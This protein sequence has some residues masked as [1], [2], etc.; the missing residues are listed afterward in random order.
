M[1][2]W[3]GPLPKWKDAEVSCQCHWGS[4]VTYSDIQNTAIKKKCLVCIR[5]VLC[6][7]FVLRARWVCT[8]RDD[9]YDGISCMV[10]WG[11]CQDRWGDN[12]VSQSEFSGRFIK[13][14]TEQRSLS[15]DSHKVAPQVGIQVGQPV[16]AELRGLTGSWLGTT[17]RPGEACH[18]LS[19]VGEWCTCSSE[20]ELFCL[21]VLS[22]K[23]NWNF[24][25]INSFHWPF[26][27]DIISDLQKNCKMG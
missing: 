21:I 4:A 19:F 13:A 18:R 9:T 17:A 22:S 16:E 7:H 3:A 14:N 15:I 1:H 25:K 11:R 5:R 6:H 24:H 10:I 20:K 8:C 12:Y 27:F 26:I 23:G 2:F